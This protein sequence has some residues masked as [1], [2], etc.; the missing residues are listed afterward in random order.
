MNLQRDYISEAILS[1]ALM[2]LERQFNA[3]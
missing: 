3:K 2:W 1:F